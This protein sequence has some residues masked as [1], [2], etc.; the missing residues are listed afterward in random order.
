MTRRR[1]STA[2]AEPIHDVLSAH[3]LRADGQ[4]DLCFAVW[5]PSEGETRTTALIAEPILPLPGERLMH[6]NASFL[7]HYFERALS[8]AMRLGGGLAFLHSHPGG[9]GWQGLS[10]DDDHAERSHAASALSAT[11]YPLVGLTHAGDTRWSARFWIRTAPK[12]Y[13]AMW[14]EN[15]R[16]V[17]GRLAIS[18]NPELRPRPRFG[19]ALVRTISAWGEDVQADFAR[20]AIGVIGA[21]SVGSM[22]AEALIRTGSEHVDLMDFDGV[23]EKNLDRLLHATAADVG[24][25]KVGVLAEGLT[26]SATG[27]NVVITTS[28]WSV[29]EERGF[30]R[31]LDCD[32]LF[33]CVDRPWPRSAMNFIAYAHLIAIVDGGIQ[34]AVTRSGK[35][36]HADWRAHTA[37]PTR[38]CLECIGQYNSG[39]VSLERNGLFDDPSYIAGLPR[40]HFVHASENVF[41]FSMAAASL[42]VLQLLTMIVAPQG[43]VSPGA[44]LYH[45]VP[46]V[47]DAADF[48]PCTAS[49]PYPE[50][51]ARGEATGIIVTA[52]HDRAERSRASRTRTSE[53]AVPWY[54]RLLA[55]LRR[56]F[57]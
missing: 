19:R 6:G 52:T 34:V 27:S 22:V 47:M 44:Q 14:C 8:E 5:F 53:T 18:W 38:R 24:R 2:M 25:A 33:S 36:R 30:R 9:S 35:L 32:V 49:C 20:T 57:A 29:V 31:A 15:V 1:Y 56:A 10:D 16:V 55:R 45:F 28:E 42:E 26:E 41:A 54:H 7:P 13:T 17:G 46:G 43:V 48:S 51:T 21:G 11:G 50:L 39:D 3:L 40:E 4:E 12:T 37:C 23:E